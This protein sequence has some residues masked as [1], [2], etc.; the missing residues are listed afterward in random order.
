MKAITLWQPWASLVAAKVKTIETRAWPAPSALIGQRIAIHAATRKPK[1][2]EKVG[3]YTIGRGTHSETLVAWRIHETH[4][5]AEDPRMTLLPLGAVVASAVL[6][7]CVPMYAVDDATDTKPDPIHDGLTEVWCT[8]D[9]GLLLAVWRRGWDT[10]T[11]EAQ[12]PFGDF[13]PGRW[14]WLLDDIAATTERCPACWGN[15]VRGFGMPGIGRC[16]VCDGKGSCEPI[17]AKG[18]QRVWNWDPA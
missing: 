7:D 4:W 1:R 18:A 8:S 14:A 6:T 16:P 15:G 13:V 3:P 2:G 5:G 10:E 9:E 12:R 17:P 11:I